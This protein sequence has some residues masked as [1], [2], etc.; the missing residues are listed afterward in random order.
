MTSRKIHIIIAVAV[1]IGVGCGVWRLLRPLY[2]PFQ[3]DPAVEASLNGIVDD[4]RKAILLIDGIELLDDATQAKC[5]AAGMMVYRRKQDAL[6]QL[7][8][9]LEGDYGLATQAGFR[10]HT[11]AIRQVVDYLSRNPSLHEDWQ[12]AISN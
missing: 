1:A 9:R 2:R 7:S 10:S 12:S 5:K 11:D 4:Y 3:K 8:G 6:E